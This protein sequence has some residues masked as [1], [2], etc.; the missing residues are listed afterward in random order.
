MAKRPQSKRRALKVAASKRVFLSA[1]VPLPSRDAAYFDTADVV[2]IRDAVR[3]L[4]IVVLEEDVQLVF[5]GHPAI[6]PMIRLQI[7]EAGISVR[8]KVVMYQSR[9]FPVDNA[10]IER[11][12]L[13]DK[14]DNDREKSLARMR[15]EM[16]SGVF[17]CGIF[18]GGMEG[19]EDEYKLF[20]DLHNKVPAF[21]IASTGAAALRIFN[22]D[23]SV[24]KHFP[25]LQE[26]ISYIGL[27][28][29]LIP[30]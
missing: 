5:G 10:A 26:E 4:T 20:V 25:E 13:I 17:S 30:S 19:V 11:V 18:I 24:Q 3:A 22:S 6:S 7:A 14:V 2:A 8:D 29:S 15:E 23:A 12:I 9:F 28:R 1:S 27:M 16:L 21:P